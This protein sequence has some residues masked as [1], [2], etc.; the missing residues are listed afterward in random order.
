MP[1]LISA[2]TPL[3]RLPVQVRRL[4]ASL[5][6]L[7]IG[8]LDIVTGE[9]A[10]FGFFYLLPVSFAAWFDTS[11]AGLIFAGL[12]ACA[13]AFANYHGHSLD[14]TPIML[15]AWNTATRLGIFLVVALLISSM[16]HTLRKL[17][18]AASLDP[19]T[20]LLNSRAFLQQ[21]AAEL[22]RS[23]RYYHPISLAY[24][25]LDDFKTIN[26]TLGHGAGDQA[27]RLAADRLKSITRRT[28]QIGRL[29]GDEFAIL[30]P[31]TGVEGAR[32]VADRLSAVQQLLGGKPGSFSGGIAT[33]DPPPENIEELIAMA[34]HL[35][36]QAKSS[37]KHLVL[38]QTRASG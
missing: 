15:I 8:G 28:D 23:R 24:I 3:E 10:S 22:A 31:E 17:E 13:W 26:D 7:A 25:D 20:G 5:L 27:L 29:G 38:Y 1:D 12:S 9:Q 34:D 11:Q 18:L 32:A 33:A 14:A 4:A 2:I 16:R 19:L 36:Y 35:M 6:L 21:A 30:L 37:G